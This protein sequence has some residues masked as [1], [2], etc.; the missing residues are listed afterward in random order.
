MKIAEK[1]ALLAEIDNLKASW[2]REMTVFAQRIER[3]N[4]ELEDRDEKIAAQRDA[5]LQMREREI[6]WRD[7]KLTA[8]GLNHQYNLSTSR[9]NDL[10][11]KLQN[12]VNQMIN[13]EKA[14]ALKKDR[15]NT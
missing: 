6:N 2:Q 8:D 15:K 12:V 4:A 1:K 14:L 9:I 5:I 3:L 7:E 13:M 10:E 11:S